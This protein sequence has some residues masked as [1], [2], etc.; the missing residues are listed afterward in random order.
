MNGA[1]RVYRDG[2]IA[3]RTDGVLELVL[4]GADDRSAGAAPGPVCGSGAC[5]GCRNA[6]G[7]RL[8]L[9]RIEAGGQ[10]AGPVDRPVRGVGDVMELSVAS[11]G[12]A[13][14]AVR[15]FGVPL[16]SLLA[17]ASIGHVAG[18]EAWSI[19]VGGAGLAAGLTWLY[20]TGRLLENLLDLELRPR[21]I[22]A[23]ADVCRHQTGVFR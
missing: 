23:V 16:A 19:V 5:G 22:I 18:G 6:R 7:R 10:G 11:A 2:V 8:E 4:G 13:A 12:L 1:V 9:S 14:I 21:P 15:A 3:A 17:G 20:R